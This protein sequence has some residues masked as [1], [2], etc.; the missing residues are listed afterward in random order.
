MMDDAVKPFRSRTSIFDLPSWESP[1]DLT[2]ICVY[3]KDGK[4]ESPRICKGNSDAACHRMLNRDV[5]AMLR[6]SED[7]AKKRFLEKIGQ[8][9]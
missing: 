8:P 4:C 1:C 5:L 2:K 9:S 7:A 6:G 3:R